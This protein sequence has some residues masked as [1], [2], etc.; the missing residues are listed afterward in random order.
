L[1]DQDSNRLAQKKEGD[2]TCLSPFA[3]LSYLL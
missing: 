2:R 1:G 3:F